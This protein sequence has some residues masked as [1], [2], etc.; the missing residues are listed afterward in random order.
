[1]RFIPHAATKASAGVTLVACALALAGCGGTATNR[2]MIPQHQPVVTHS[3]FSLDLTEGADG[4]APSEKARLSGWFDAMGL[5]Y[6]DQIAI[7]DPA[8]NAKTRAAV[9]DLAAA[10]G[11][12]IS[13]QPPL[14]QAALE[15]GTLRIVLT[16]ASATV[17][18]CPDWSANSETNTMNAL[19]PNFGCAVNSN[20]AAMVANPDD[21][22]HGAHSDGNP[23]A[24]SNKAISTYRDAKPTG[25]GGTTLTA[26][27]TKG[28]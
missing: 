21:L 22:L 3:S 8:A 5:R 15:P 6:G 14:A 17:P 23:V 27:S 4:I 26:T 10:K 7:D 18:G 1:M 2:L 28:S 24:T 16:R 25:S 19:H 13:P 11:L 9:A 20:L 12:M